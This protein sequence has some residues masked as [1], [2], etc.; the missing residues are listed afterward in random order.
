MANWDKLRILWID[1]CE[2]DHPTYRYPEPELP[3]HLQPYLSIV[4]KPGAVRRSSL[5]SP[6]EFSDLFGPFW[7]DSDRSMFPVEIVAMDYVLSKW[8]PVRINTQYDK[9]AEDRAV[10]Q[11]IEAF[12]NA[13]LSTDSSHSSDDQVH[14]YEGL[15][16]GVFYASLTCDYPTGLVPMTNYGDQ[17]EKIP[18]VKALHDIS[19]PLLD[20]D[21]SNFGVSGEDRNWKNVLS[22]GL[23][24][25]RYRIVSLFVNRRINLSLADMVTMGDAPEEAVLTLRSNYGMRRLPV[26]GLF[27]DVEDPE[28]RTTEIKDWAEELLGEAEDEDPFEAI[29]E[30]RTIAEQ[31]WSRYLNESD[32]I[33]RRW[34]LS[35]LCARKR[36][37]GELGEDQEAKLLKLYE[38]F[39]VENPAAQIPITA[40]SRVI[41]I[42]DDSVDGL[43]IRWASVFVLAR[44]IAHLLQCQARLNKKSGSE[45]SRSCFSHFCARD[46]LYALMP[47]PEVP[48]ILPAHH[49]GRNNPASAGGT[50][51]RKLRRLNS[52][53][54]SDIDD[55]NLGNCGFD[56]EHVFAGKGREGGG[57]GL[58]PV[59]RRLLES[60][61]TDHLV[62]AHQ[63][64]EETEK[65]RAKLPLSVHTILQGVQA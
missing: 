22:Q 13:G 29:A 7:A 62:H 10:D 19:K 56:V 54:Y 42:C 2:S 50:L 39:G 40:T 51:N 1:D 28:D 21:Y 5:R 30:A 58:R 17:M 3:P 36:Q 46:W 38:F 6:G 27:A 31:H 43:T 15:L 24:A 18:E 26:A 49:K 20:I 34:R 45:T 8:A 23:K 60:A 55:E 44:L 63:D 41:N 48:L 53:Q 9:S 61:V 12:R 32:M 35:E 47:S 52:S 33:C 57:L 65:F 4:R 59:E 64:V 37:N 16:I 14:T 11:A 25:L